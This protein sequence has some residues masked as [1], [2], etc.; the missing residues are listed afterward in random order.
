MPDYIKID[1]LL[2]CLSSIDPIG[3]LLQK[4]YPTL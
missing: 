3:F 4:P 1:L 2:E